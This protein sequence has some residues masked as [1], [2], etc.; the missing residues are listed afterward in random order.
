MEWNRLTDD[1]F[2]C[3]SEASLIQLS[4]FLSPAFLV[5]T[6]FKSLCT[7]SFRFSNFSSTQVIGIYFGVHTNKQRS[8]SKCGDRQHHGPKY[9]LCSDSQK[10][11]RISSEPDNNTTHTTTPV[12]PLHCRLQPRNPRSLSRTRARQER[13]KTPQA[14][15]VT[16]RH[17]RSV[18]TPPTSL[19]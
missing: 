6:K 16:P 2:L 1:F 8:T 10:Y 17:P 12:L 18:T 7:A 3:E 14:A 11:K 15:A 19:T 13:D 5:Q 9:K 4:L